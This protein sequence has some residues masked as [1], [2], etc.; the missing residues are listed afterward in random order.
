MSKKINL[1]YIAEGG[2]FLSVFDS[3][4]KAFLNHIRPHVSQIN[5]LIL[6]PFYQRRFKDVIRN[7]K[8][9][10][11]RSLFDSVT[12]F[13]MPPIIGLPSIF[14]VAKKITRC[15]PNINPD[16]IHARGHIGSYI[17]LIIK[18]KLFK[19]TPLIADLRGVPREEFLFH[20]RGKINKL[21]IAKI[22]IVGFD[23]MEQYV[24]R[25]SAHIFCVSESLSYYLKE[26]VEVDGDKITVVPTCTDTN[27]FSYDQLKYEKMRT[28]LGI[29]DRIV[30]IYSGSLAPWQM[31]KETVELFK[32]IKQDIKQVFLLFLTIE[33]EKAK[34]IFTNMPTEDYL[35]TSAKYSEVSSYLNAADIGILLRERHIV[36]KVS[37]PVKIGEYLC[38]GLPILI[39]PDIGDLESQIREYGF[40]A[41]IQNDN[42]QII[43]K[44]IYDVLKLD[45]SFISKVGKQLYSLESHSKK[46]LEVYNN[47]YSYKKFNKR[48]KTTNYIINLK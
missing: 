33:P 48:I 34:D 41:I 13:K 23:Y 43:V 31:V 22:R 16:I 5:L 20:A 39:S 3:Q 27:I 40:G 2:M 38:C 8:V 46:V 42:H 12:L 36:N 44:K 6:E 37:A 24:C 15:I 25:E 1:L 32:K 30:F 10:E 7:A 28:D 47:L 45:R 35:I 21:I 17:G 18:N 26:N 14:W 9:S 11:L 29:K 4:V 19:D